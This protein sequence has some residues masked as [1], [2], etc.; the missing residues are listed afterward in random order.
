MP[1]PES[2][3]P[4]AAPVKL[5]CSFPDPATCRLRDLPPQAARIDLSIRLP[6][7]PIKLSPGGSAIPSESGSLG[8]RPA[9]ADHRSRRS[10]RN[11]RLERARLSGAG[12]DGDPQ[13]YL[14]EMFRAEL[15][16]ACRVATPFR[17]PRSREVPALMISCFLDPAT[18]SWHAESA[19]KIAGQGLSRRSYWGSYNGWLPMIRC[20]LISLH[21]QPSAGSSRA[22]TPSPPGRP[23]RPTRPDGTSPI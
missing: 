9:E 3:E 18:P 11:R 4:D 2:P 20:V 7:A 16:A 6:A 1:L 21:R 13:S 10:A 8:R 17:T 14:G 23:T 19:A 22:T 12:R 5:P 15:I